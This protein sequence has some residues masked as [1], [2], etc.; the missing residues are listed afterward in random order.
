MKRTFSSLAL[1]GLLIV[2]GDG[3]GVAQD[4]GAGVAAYERGDYATAFREMSVLSEQG[5][6][7]AQHNL[8]I[9]YSE[10]QGVTQDY[11][12][13]A[14]WFRL[15][16]ERGNWYAQFSLGQLYRNGQGVTQDYREAAK[17][18]RLSA[19]QGHADAQNNLG[20]M[21]VKGQGVTQDYIYAHMWFNIAASTGSSGAIKNRDMVADKM[22]AAQIATAQELAKQCV[23]QDFKRC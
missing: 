9:M 8:G 1:G 3:I 19:E 21:F 17:W 23:A 13:A 12:E 15:S 22:T 2:G 6:S 18:L 20:V 7:S 14:K 5:N 11:R 16:A 10:G 4:F